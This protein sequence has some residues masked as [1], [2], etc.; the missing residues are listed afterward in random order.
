M[1]A[2]DYTLDQVDLSTPTGQPNIFLE[3]ELYEEAQ[4]P[5]IEC[6]LLDAF[7]WIY[8]T[9]VLKNFNIG[10]LRVQK[11]KYKNKV[12]ISTFGSRP[13]PPKSGKNFM[14]FFSETRPFLS[15]FCKNCIFP[16]WKVKKI[17]QKKWKNCTLCQFIVKNC[18]QGGAR[19]TPR[20]TPPYT[21]KKI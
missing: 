5:F 16:L 1:W 9:F 14:Y 12:E 15:T 10:Y 7:W 18:N 13:L 6:V 8:L 19:G 17:F 21:W 20:G 2:R 3:R 4:E 11:K